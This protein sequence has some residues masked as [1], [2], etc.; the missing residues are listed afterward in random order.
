[1]KNIRI[2]GSEGEMMLLQIGQH[3]RRIIWHLTPCDYFLWGTL[4]S[5]VYSSPLDSE[6]E[7]HRRILNA[8]NSLKNNAQT[9]QRVQFNFLRRI[10]LCIEEN[11]GH[12]E[13]LL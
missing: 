1:M 7:L 13:N 8:A 4:K 11:G 12:F 3:D 5:K 9:M 6:E 2:D 10:N